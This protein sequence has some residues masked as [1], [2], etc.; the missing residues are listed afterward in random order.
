MQSPKSLQNNTWDE[1]VVA[2]DSTKDGVDLAW[3]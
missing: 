1:D 2:Q 3:K